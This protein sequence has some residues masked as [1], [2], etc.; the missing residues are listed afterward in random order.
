[1]KMNGTKL[2]QLWLAGAVLA[3]LTA[4]TATLIFSQS[5]GAH[6][7]TV[8]HLPPPHFTDVSGAAVTQSNY[9]FAQGI[10]SG[11]GATTFCPND[12]LDR[13]TAAVL[14]IRAIFS[15]KNGAGSANADNFTFTASPYFTDVPATHPQ[16]KWIQ[17]M[18]DLALTSGCKATQYCPDDKVQNFEIA[19]FSARAK[20]F[21]ET[22]LAIPST[23]SFSP[24]PYFNDE[25]LTSDATHFPF[26]QR[27]G[28]LGVFGK[29]AASA[30]CKS[31]SFCATNSIT[32]GQ[33]LAYITRGILGQSF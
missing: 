8:I 5:P 20:Q 11:C 28:D 1:M 27:E 19:I 15:S 24:T 9:L 30:G 2:K 10:T 16:F 26:I 12:N 3:G 13:S 7:V 6:T 23:F 4:L 25:T 32:R 29:P 21:L 17:K 14:I 31:G 18:K 33:S 22:G